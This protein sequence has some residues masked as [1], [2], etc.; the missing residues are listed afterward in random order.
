MPLHL[1]D[2]LSNSGTALVLH[3]E[4]ELRDVDLAQLRDFTEG[5]R[6]A[7][8]AVVLSN[9]DI[10]GE[11]FLYLALLPNLR[12]LYVNR[13]QIKDN[14]PFELFL[15][16]LE[17]ANLDNTEAGDVSVSKLKMAPNLRVLSL[18]HTR[19]TEH[20]VRLLDNLRNLREY[21]LEG[22][23]VSEH[24]KQ[25]L[26]NTRGLDAMSVGLVFDWFLY[27][28]RG[29]AQ[30][31][32][33]YIRRINKIRALRIHKMLARLGIS[34]LRY[35]HKARPVDIERHLLVCQGC[36]KTGDCDAYLEQGKDIDPSTF[37][38]DARE[39]QTYKLLAA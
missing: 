35:L 24:A 4:K 36:R 6:A 21:Y 13:T 10:T 33:Q 2:Y 9:T 12:D 1:K 23:A 14:A 8:I 26:D 7:I 19:V 38:P 39:L 32:A 25:R 28:I 22:T 27:S 18:R 11:C 3:G 20:A 17:G 31:L 30:K 15:E 34:L 5:Q 37:C 16:T 29:G